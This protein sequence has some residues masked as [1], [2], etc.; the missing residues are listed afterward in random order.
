MSS[1]EGGREWG[2]Q[3]QAD[4]V[5]PAGWMGGA[6]AWRRQEPGLPGTP[7]GTSP[8]RTVVSACETIS[9]LRPP[10]CASQ[11]VWFRPSCA[12]VSQLE[13]TLLTLGVYYGSSW[14]EGRGQPGQTRSR[15]PSGGG[16]RRRAGTVE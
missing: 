9:G 2:P 1:R 5:L 11:R 7:G 14:Q 6:W 16:G 15:A 13:Q 4:P 10:V 8:A 3:R 12:D